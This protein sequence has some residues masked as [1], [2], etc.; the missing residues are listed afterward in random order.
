[1]CNYECS[2]SKIKEI[3]GKV[4]IDATAKAQLAK[5]LNARRHLF[6]QLIPEY[7]E[8]SLYPENAKKASNKNKE[9][10][11]R[12]LEQTGD[13]QIC[14]C[15]LILYHIRNNLMHGMKLLEELNGQLELFRAAN[16][17]LESIH[18]QY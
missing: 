13:Q 10:M 7:V 15:L 4:P 11:Q 17:V 3:A 9:I 8:E 1:M 14:G 2:P 6:N 12:Y 18:E 5:V 16:A